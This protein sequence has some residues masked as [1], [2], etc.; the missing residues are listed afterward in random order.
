MAAPNL[1][2]ATTA[3][4]KT[5]YITPANTSANVLLA[6]SAASN[7]VLKINMINV[8]N[9][10]GTNAFNATVSLNTTAAGGGTTYQI[11]STVSVPAN[12]S[13]LVS[14]KASTFYLEEDKSILVT[15]SSANK[16]VFTVSYEEI[17]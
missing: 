16:L 1:F 13:L 9:V 14:D 17:G 12:A 6:N 7:K 11:A 8:S 3:T 15:S 5:A 4:G 2:A 10:D